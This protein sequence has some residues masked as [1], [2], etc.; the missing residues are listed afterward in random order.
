MKGQGLAFGLDY[1]FEYEELK[2]T[3]DPGQVII[4]GTD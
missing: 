4:I 1:N 3:V 2:R